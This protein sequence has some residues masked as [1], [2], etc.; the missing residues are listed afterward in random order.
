MDRAQ[1]PLG[2]FTVRGIFEPSECEALRQRG[3]TIGYT[4]API[5]TAMGPIMAPGVRSN[6][7]AMLDDPNI[8]QWV[9]GRLAGKLVP[10]VEDDD[11]TQWTMSGLNE[12]FRFYRYHPGQSFRWH[13]DASF[14]RNAQ[15]RS[16]FSL[17][18]YLNDDFEGGE[19]EFDLRQGFHR[20]NPEQGMVLVF[21]HPLRHQGAAVVR[22]VKYVLRTDVMYRRD[23][24]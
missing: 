3:E 11:G 24:R 7:R 4:A 10:S 9:E 14:R 20:V 22:G 5:T 6:A 19:T 8:S 15:E 21:E 1:R 16:W 18:I 13:L 2:F 23:P 17:I 12:R